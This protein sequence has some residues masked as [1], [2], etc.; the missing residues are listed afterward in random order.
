MQKPRSVVRLFGVSVPTFV[1]ERP[2]RT[3]THFSL[4]L[5][6][7]VATASEALAQRTE[8]EPDRSGITARLATHTDAARAE[9]LLS[10]AALYEAS[11]D[12]SDWIRAAELHRRSAALQPLGNEAV[13]RS[14]HRAAHIYHGAGDY[15]LAQQLLEEAVTTARIY[16]NIAREAEAL[17]AAAWVAEVRD[18]TE[19]FNRHL[20]RAFLLTYAPLL[21]E[22]TRVEVQRRVLLPPA[23]L[24]ASAVAMTRPPR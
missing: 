6:A 1:L 13:F 7:A 17:L 20:S 12:R 24:T 16:G 8:S 4:I 2:M 14:L 15:E 21:P 9:A 18:D 23:L 5:L 10:E 22:A 19:A 11:A 3:R